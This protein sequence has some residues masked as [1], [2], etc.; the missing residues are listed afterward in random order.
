MRRSAAAVVMGVVSVLLPAKIASG[1][2]ILRLGAAHV[3]RVCPIADGMTVLAPD[4]P[5]QPGDPPPSIE[6][7]A[8]LPDCKDPAFGPRRPEPPAASGDRR[9]ASQPRTVSVLRE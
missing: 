8:P 1:Q 6:A 7:R 2:S 5:W 9:G 3:D 4:R